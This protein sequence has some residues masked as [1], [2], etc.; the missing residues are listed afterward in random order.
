MQCLHSKLWMILPFFLATISEEVNFLE[1]DTES[2]IQKAIDEDKMVFI[3]FS[4]DWCA[5]CKWMEQH[6]FADEL[7]IYWLNDGFISL[8]ADIETAL[9]QKI[10]KEFGVRSVPTIVFLDQ[11][12]NVLKR[13]NTSV[14]PELTKEIIQ[15][16]K[17]SQEQIQTLR[18]PSYQISDKKARISRPALVPEKLDDAMPMVYQDNSPQ[19]INTPEDLN[20]EPQ[21]ETAP[22]EP[23]SYR[24]LFPPFDNYQE[25]VKNAVKIEHQMNRQ[26]EF[27]L[28]QKGK[29]PLYT[30]RLNQIKSLTQAK[31]YQQQLKV[32]G[33]FT[34]I[35]E[36]H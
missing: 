27:S 24:L 29:T 31:K 6:T 20:P 26:V 25:A 32:V 23:K 15:K 36:Y 34:T 13:V 4:A 11:E 30:L 5:P 1:I 16:I 9:G 8:K 3:Y 22:R 28:E 19:R 2:A 35:E 14:S 17:A 7:V 10:Q 21:V 33:Y 18:S 12:K